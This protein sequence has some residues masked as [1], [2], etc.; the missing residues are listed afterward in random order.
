LLSFF[1]HSRG[2]AG[3]SGYGAAR[4]KLAEKLETRLDQYV[5]DLLDMLHAETVVVPVERIHAYLEV[6]AR[7]SDMAVGEKAGQIVRRRAAAA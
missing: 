6:C 5:E 4:A 3:Q 1:D 2:S 7:F